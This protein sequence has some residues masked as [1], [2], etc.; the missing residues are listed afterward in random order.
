VKIAEIVGPRETIISQQPD[1]T[2][3]H[4]IVKVQI[5]VAPMCKEFTQYAK[6][7]VS[8]KLGHEAAGVV[9]D[10]A[11]SSRVSIGQR[12]VVM[13]QYGCGHCTLCMSGDHIH[14]LDQRDVLTETGSAVGTATYAE[15]VLK[16]DWL[17]LPVP[18][19]VRLS[20]AALA[21]CGLGPTFN[22]M[23]RMRVGA[24]DT[25]LVSG[26]G[27]V[28]LG[29]IVNARARG[30]RVLAVEISEYRAKLAQA[31]GAAAVVD[32][33]AEDAAA[34]IVALT[35]GR[36]VDAAVDTSNAPG[37]ASLIQ[38]A[39]RRRGRVAFVGWGG[40][41]TLTKFV[42][43]GLDVY[44]CWHWNHQRDGDLMIETIRRSGPL[45]DNLVTHEFPLDRVADAFEIQLT[46]NCGKI[47]LYP[48][49]KEA[50]R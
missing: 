49:G 16:P 46:G 42:P 44:G 7:G 32:P 13:P 38:A 29:G 11:D 19:D 2:A 25:V 1:P 27:P 15:Y 3:R 33:T 10:A 34:Q 45:L 28:G 23:Q 43:Q 39:T 17:L 48:R 24:L 12:V 20:H 31:L 26:C 47:L 40:T 22:A 41:I 36:G 37:A 18:D 21:C 50:A 35:D 14:C 8:S 5:L 4:D 30:A 6:G 9:V